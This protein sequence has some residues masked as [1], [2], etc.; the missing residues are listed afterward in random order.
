MA[1]FSVHYH[2]LECDGCECRPTDSRNLTDLAL[3]RIAESK[4]WTMDFDQRTGHCRYL[5]QQCAAEEAKAK[6]NA[7]AAMAEPMPF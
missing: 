6:A 3:E 7:Q 1:L 4:G 5:C 2:V